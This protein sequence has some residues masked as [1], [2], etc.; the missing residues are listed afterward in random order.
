MM[1]H[2]RMTLSMPAEATYLQVGWRS[3]DMM[4]SLWPLRDLMRQGSYSL[5]MRLRFKLLKNY[6]C[7]NYYQGSINS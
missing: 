6:Q 3:M 1:S 2:R 4:D 5:C 7:L